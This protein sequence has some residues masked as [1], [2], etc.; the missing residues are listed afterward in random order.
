M[1]KRK[2]NESYEDY[3]VRRKKEK[4]QEKRRLKGVKVWPGD[5]GTYTKNLHGR[6]ED[7][8]KEMMQKIKNK[9]NE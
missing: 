7:K 8:L 4:D 1:T 6:V 9:N 2:E 3:K 5:W